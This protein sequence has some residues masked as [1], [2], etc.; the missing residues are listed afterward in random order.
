[1]LRLRRELAFFKK[2]SSPDSLSIVLQYSSF[3]F[4]SENLSIDSIDRALSQNLCIEKNL[5]DPRPGKRSTKMNLFTTKSFRDH[6]KFK[7]LDL[8]YG[9]F[10]ETSG[11]LIPSNLSSGDFV[12]L[13][14][15]IEQLGAWAKAH[16]A[17]VRKSIAQQFQMDA[18][19]VDEYFNI[20]WL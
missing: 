17:E 6:N 15:L 9:F 7:T 10:L 11:K 3:L 5:K 4:K 13:V 19:E 16:E 14:K 12:S 8:I 1:M 20:N 18:Q 2:I